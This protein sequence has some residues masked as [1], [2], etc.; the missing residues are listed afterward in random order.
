MFEYDIQ[1]QSTIIF[2]EIHSVPKFHSFHWKILTGNITDM[3]SKYATTVTG[4]H[5]K[6]LLYDGVSFRVA[7][8]KFSLV[9]YDL[10]QD[11]FDIYTLQVANKIGQRSCSVLLKPASKY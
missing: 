4:T 8:W 3:S 10:N 11:D 2:I 7:I 9:I 1:G 6:T 5:F